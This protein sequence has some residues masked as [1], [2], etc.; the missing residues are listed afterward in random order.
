M[1]GH[2]ALLLA[3]GVLW[4]LPL[5]LPYRVTQVWH[6]LRRRPSA[7]EAAW[8]RGRLSPAQQALFFAQQ[9]GDQA[10]AIHVARTLAAQGH[11]DERLLQAALLHDIGKAPGVSLFHRTLVVLLKRGAPRLLARLAPDAQ[12][13]LAPL[14]RAYHHP[15][16]GAELARRA[17]S[18]PDTVRLIA[19]HQER[20]P[21]LPPALQGWLAALQA[22][23]DAS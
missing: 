2:V 12:G 4:L 7:E 9:A 17:G 18:H 8:A 1:L 13:W 16:L 6:W 23:D 19:H 10:H 21:A 3:A 14:A 11:A 5:A 15:A 22:V 20:A